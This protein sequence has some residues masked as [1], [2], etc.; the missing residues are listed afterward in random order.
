MTCQID[1]RTI[2]LRCFSK[3]GL[4]VTKITLCAGNTFLDDACIEKDLF[5]LHLLT[6]LDFDI[7]EALFLTEFIY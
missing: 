6:Y 1:G 7:D 3:V 4:E 5:V 2:H